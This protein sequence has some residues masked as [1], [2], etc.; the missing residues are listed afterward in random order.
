[1]FDVTGAGD[2]VIAV[3]TLGLAA[4]LNLLLAAQLAN[5]AAGL[6]VR[7]LGNAAPTPEELTWAVRNW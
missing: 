2:T 4:G 3:A 6:V 1:V 7:K 5:Y